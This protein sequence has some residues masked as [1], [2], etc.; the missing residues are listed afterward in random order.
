MHNNNKLKVYSIVD[1]TK[2]CNVYATWY[3]IY[4]PNVV[5]PISVITEKDKADLK[6]GLGL[7]VDWVAQSF[8]Q[9]PSDV[10]ELRELVGDQV[11]G[12]V[13][14][15]RCA[16]SAFFREVAEDFCSKF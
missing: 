8:V 11:A 9:Q 4:V 15:V 16:Q 7:G 5:L 2:C 10:A 3:L 14:M 6:Y 12:G 13:C 1:I